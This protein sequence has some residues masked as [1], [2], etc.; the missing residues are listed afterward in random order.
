MKLNRH[1]VPIRLSVLL[2]ATLLLTPGFTPAGQNA[3][4]GAG[5][6]GPGTLS[7]VLADPRNVPVYVPPPPG[8][9]S[10]APMRI[11][12]V[13]ITVNYNPTGPTGCGPN[14]AAWPADA[15]AAFE[16]GV[17]IWR[18]TLNG[19][20]PIVVDA[21]WRTD[22]ALNILGSAGSSAS[23]ENF[24]GAPQSNTFYPVPLANQ[25]ANT[26]LNGGAVEIQARFNANQSWYRGLD[27]KVP[28][29]QYDLVTVVLHEMGHGLGF[30][31]GMNWDN[32]VAGDGK[33]CDNIAGDGCWGADPF[34][35]DRFTRNVTGTLISLGNNT[36]ALGNA[37]I[38]DG[39]SFNGPNAIAANGGTA[40]RLDAPNPWVGGSSYS[41]L[42][43]GTY[44]AGTLDALMTPA[45]AAQEAI[46]YPGAIVL[47]TFRDLG[48]N[49][50]D[51]SNTYVDGGYVG[52]E[53]GTLT[54]PFNTVIEGVGA[55][56]NGGTVWIQAGNYS[57]AVA[58]LHPMTLRALNGTV[59]I[60][61][62]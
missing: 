29:N 58:V 33:E 23:Y 34:I 51:L 5:Q 38:S 30:T 27:G 22:L 56:A 11:D 62:P 50:P 10:N 14:V 20:Q 57:G 12:A 53:D 13:Q 2:I 15:R 40:P 43:E 16:Y 31:G 32:G 47:G 7:V 36:A 24:S 46:H 21:C 8:F 35:Y 28:V 26:D 17:S 19:T 6:A 54:R 59:V 37:L 18:W 39:L 49:M 1:S 52:V 48:W 61:T 3:I 25:L 42:R 60:G 41:H 45:L 9:N 55:V 44:T 4:G